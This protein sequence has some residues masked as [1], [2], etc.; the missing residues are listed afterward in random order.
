MYR[1][2]RVASKSDIS[3]AISTHDWCDKCPELITY[4]SEAMHSVNN[5]TLELA[6]VFAY[7][8]GEHTS[9]LVSIT[10]VAETLLNTCAS[11]VLYVEEP[12]P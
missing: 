3:K 4:I 5:V 8:I 10:E 1:E 2:F 12:L 7:T 11:V 6:T 9:E